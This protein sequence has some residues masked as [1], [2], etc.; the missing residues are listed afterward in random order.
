M[1]DGICNQRDVVLSLRDKFFLES[2]CRG[3]LGYQHS[4]TSRATIRR[5]PRVR[6]NAPSAMRRSSAML[7]APPSESRWLS[8]RFISAEFRRSGEK[9]FSSPRGWVS[10]HAST[11]D[12]GG[13]GFRECATGCHDEESPRRMVVVAAVDVLGGQ[14]TADFSRAISNCPHDGVQRWRK[15]RRMPSAPA[16]DLSGSIELPG[17]SKV[18]RFAMTSHSKMR[19]GKTSDVADAPA[20]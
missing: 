18:S 19:K 3:V 9:M 11:G 16:D 4:T 8:R 1:Q 6:Q 7:F 13:H 17:R 5:A 20:S 2:R 14:L 15:R 12:N 10:D